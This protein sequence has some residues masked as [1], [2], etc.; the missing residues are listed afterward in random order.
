MDKK[1]IFNNNKKIFKY[2][3]YINI[4]WIFIINNIQ[5]IITLN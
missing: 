5:I 3:F 2:I 4:I 1:F